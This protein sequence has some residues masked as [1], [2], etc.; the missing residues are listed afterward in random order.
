MLF[1]F[2]G[3]WRVSN[4]QHLQV[5]PLRVYFGDTAAPSKSKEVSLSVAAKVDGI[6]REENSGRSEEIF[7]VVVLTEKFN[8]VSKRDKAWKSPLK[9]YNL[10]NEDNNA[11]IDDFNNDTWD[12]VIRLPI[13]PYSKGMSPGVAEATFQLSVTEVGDG[14]R[15]KILR[16]ANKGL[17]LFEDDVT[18]AL[19]EAATG[20]IGE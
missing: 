9:F 1:D 15:K 7:D 10:T 17:N 5:R 3:Q 20:L 19:E 11:Y 4:D 2:V 14:A 12:D 13:I 6:W 18:S 16:L 8:R